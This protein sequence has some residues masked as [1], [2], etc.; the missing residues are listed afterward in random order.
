[1]L[2][3]QATAGI[4]WFAL[5]RFKEGEFG[6]TFRFT[7]G[8]LPAAGDPPTSIPAGRFWLSNTNE[9]FLALYGVCTHLG[10]L[11]KWDNVNARFSCPCHGSQF[12]LNGE[13]ITGPAP[14]P[15]DRFAVTLTFADG[16]QIVSDDAGNPIQIGDRALDTVV[17]VAVDTGNRVQRPN[18]G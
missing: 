16:T 15:M 4:I 13:W 2:L 5:P 17:D 12:E 7:G 10:C 1:M 9:G 14:R 6:G 8:D 18:H 3:G 11:P